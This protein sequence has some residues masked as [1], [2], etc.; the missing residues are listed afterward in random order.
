M[1]ELEI[2]ETIQTQK[3]KD[4]DALEHQMPL[5]DEGKTLA[6]KKRF[7]FDI[8]NVPTDPLR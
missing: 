8:I 6:E 7:T 3:E 5:D 2:M 4:I 1:R